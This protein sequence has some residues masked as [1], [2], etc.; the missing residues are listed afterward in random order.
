MKNL[1]LILLCVLFFLPAAKG[2][3]V[4]YE[5]ARKEKVKFS[6]ILDSLF[7]EKNYALIIDLC[8]GPQPDYLSSICTCNLI[9]TY[10]F[11]GDSVKSWELLNKEINK[12]KA[13]NDINAYSLD[14]V[15]STGDYTSFK[16]FQINSTVKNYFLK[17]IDSFYKTEMVSDKENGIEL[18][19]LLLEDQWIRRTSSLY[20][21]LFPERRFPLPNQMDSTQALQIL[22]NHCTK[23]FK[24]YKEHNKVFS[25]AEVGKMYYWQLMLF[26]HEQDL[27][28]REF[29]HELI[30]Q[31]VKDGS[32]KMENQMNFEIGTRYIQLGIDEFFKQ[33]E[34]I[35]EEYR[36]KYSKPDFRIRLM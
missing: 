31:G 27:I 13:I 36:A 28:R 5:V 12:L 32:L 20:D 10:Y 30:K 9:G 23:V 29:Y 24:F 33:R 4:D 25:T 35:Q 14:N 6:N 34:L 15:F 26:F 16:K 11:M 1:L 21:K 3:G 7:L 2:Q 19:H 8:S 22:N 17:I 18:L